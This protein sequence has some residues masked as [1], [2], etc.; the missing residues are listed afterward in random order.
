MI[1]IDPRLIAK[2]LDFVM[3]GLLT[4]EGH[5]VA[6]VEDNVTVTRPCDAD[7]SNASPEK[8]DKSTVFNTLICKIDKDN[9]IMINQFNKLILMY[10][11]DYV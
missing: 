4:S 7:V 8:L 9:K 11:Y 5:S 10:L 6:L 2:L 1:Q 3:L